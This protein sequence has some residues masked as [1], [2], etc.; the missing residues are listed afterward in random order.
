MIAL[1]GFIQNSI[2]DVA[3]KRKRNQFKAT[4]V[5]VAILCLSGGA[6]V[7]LG[8]NLGPGPDA[9]MKNIAFASPLRSRC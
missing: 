5:K 3:A 2:D 8:L 6:T 1:Q 4:A 7:L 9:S